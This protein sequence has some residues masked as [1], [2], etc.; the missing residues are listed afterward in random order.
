MSLSI[1]PDGHRLFSLLGY[2]EQWC[3]ECEN[4]GISFETLIS[5]LWDKCPRVGFLGHMVFL[6]LS[7]EEP[8]PAFHSSCTILHSHQE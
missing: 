6:F 7:F 1:N 3:N 4:T 8:P 5:V 2:C